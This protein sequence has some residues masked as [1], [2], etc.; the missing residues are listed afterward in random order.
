[1]LHYIM[2]SAESVY[3]D[4]RAAFVVT[5]CRKAR[6]LLCNPNPRMIAPRQMVVEVVVS[7]LR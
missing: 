4:Q 2:N 1:M 7:G 3:C 5:I 6:G